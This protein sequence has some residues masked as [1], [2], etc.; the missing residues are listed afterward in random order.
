MSGFLGFSV[1]ELKSASNPWFSQLIESENDE[2][3]PV[4]LAESSSSSREK[5]RSKIKKGISAYC[6]T[7]VI[8]V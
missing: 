4:K 1:S 6:I 5:R 2:A 3:I 8:V 7:L